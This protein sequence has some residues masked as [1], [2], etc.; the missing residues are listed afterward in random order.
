MKRR[1]FFKSLFAAGMVIAAPK[2]LDVNP[3]E[4]TPVKK[5]AGRPVKILKK[6][7]GTIFCGDKVIANFNDVEINTLRNELDVSTLYDENGDFNPRIE[8][9]PGYLESTIIESTITVHA[10]NVDSELS[11]TAFMKGNIV[12]LSINVDNVEVTT[13]GYL[14]SMSFN[15]EDYYYQE[16]VIKVSGS[17]IM[18]V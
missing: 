6:Y 3:V 16:W 18:Y 14:E 1:N 17:T 5:K 9:I 8:F 12:E 10:V 13:N 15:F 11:K 2:I 7:K 4:A